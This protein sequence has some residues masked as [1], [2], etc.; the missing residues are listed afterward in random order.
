MTYLLVLPKIARE[1]GPTTFSDLTPQLVESVAWGDT[2]L[3]VTFTAQPTATELLHIKIRALSVD[4]AAE[5]V[6]RQALAAYQTNVG[7]LA[8]PAPTTVQALT[9]VSTLTRHVNGL[10]RYLV[11]ID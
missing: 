7:Y 5:T 10:I 9:Q 8:I 4:A 3:G 2:G 6:L 11:P 1:I